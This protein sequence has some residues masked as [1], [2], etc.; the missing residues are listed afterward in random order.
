MSAVSEIDLK[1]V[2]PASHVALPSKREQLAKHYRWL[3]QELAN[4]Y[5]VLPWNPRKID[6]LADEISMAE[7]R[8]IALGG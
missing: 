2:G 7:H 8:L 1:L 5:S 4:A 3:T 6:R